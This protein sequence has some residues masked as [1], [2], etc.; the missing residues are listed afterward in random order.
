MKGKEI[1][2]TD[3]WN[4]YFNGVLRKNID[5]VFQNEWRLL[6]PYCEVKCE[7]C[8]QYLNGLENVE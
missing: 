1:T 7:N 6:L 3:V 5:W 2:P 4:I 8:I